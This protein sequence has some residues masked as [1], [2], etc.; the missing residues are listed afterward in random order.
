MLKKQNP[1]LNIKIHGSDKDLISVATAPGLMFQKSAVPDFYSD[2][3]IEGNTGLQFQNSLKDLIMFEFRDL[4][5]LEVF[6]RL[7]MV[8]IRDVLSFLKVELQNRVIQVILDNLKENGVLILGQN[9]KLPNL[10]GWED[11]SANGISAYRKK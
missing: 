3:M 8:I 6:S 11:I 2:F 7:D 4:E 1:D 5:N 10:N 9:E